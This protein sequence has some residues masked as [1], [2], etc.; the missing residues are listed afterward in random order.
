MNS[1]D[2]QGR[3]IQAIKDSLLM[4]KSLIL[5]KT[6]EF[7]QEQSSFGQ[8]S[9]ESEAV[10]HNISSHISIH[11]HERDRLALLQIERALGRISSGIY[12][13]C[14]SCTEQIGLRRLQARPFATLCISCMEDQENMKSQFPQ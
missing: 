1:A 9:D 7:I 5:N 2:L 6:H 4:Q 11:L 12:G 3:E 14:E 13:Q 10:S 8:I